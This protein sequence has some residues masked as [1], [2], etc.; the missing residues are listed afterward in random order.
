M[1]VWVVIGLGVVYHMFV[2]MA[3]KKCEW[4]GCHKC[5]RDGCHRCV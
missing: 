3:C 2:G 1:S 5:V 4:L